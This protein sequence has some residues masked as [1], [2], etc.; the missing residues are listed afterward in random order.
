MI[1]ALSWAKVG[2][3]FTSGPGLILVIGL[4]L[5]TWHKLD[6]SSAVREAVVSY[7]ADAELAAAEAEQRVLQERAEN[8]EAANAVLRFQTERDER[9]LADAQKALLEYVESNPSGCTVSDDLTD[10]LLWD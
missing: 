7:V 2:R 3:F 1:A 6:K 8:L 10:R 5:F 9:K 4:A